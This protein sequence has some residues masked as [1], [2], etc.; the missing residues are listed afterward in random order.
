MAQINTNQVRIQQVKFR[1][2]SLD[3]HIHKASHLL[4]ENHFMNR[5]VYS[6]RDYGL[7]GFGT[8]TQLI[9]NHKSGIFLTAGSYYWQ[10]AQNK[11]PK[12]D[13][14][15]GYATSL[16]ERLSAS[17]AYSHSLYLGASAEQLRWV[18]T[19]FISTYWT[20]DVGFMGISP[21]FYYQVGK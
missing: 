7:T 17:F 14:T 6:G 2:D 8:S 5:V 10:K 16:D 20:I 13:A 4:L 21:S 15:I 19:D 11:F 1:L 18:T 9:Y 3:Y 12:V